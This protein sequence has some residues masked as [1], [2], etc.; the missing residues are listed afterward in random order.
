M[1]A[2]SIR[3]SRWYVKK[4]ARAGVAAGVWASGALVGR[5][6]LAP[7]VRVRALT[8][9]RFGHIPQDPFCVAPEDFEAQVR[10]L[11]ERKLAVSLDDVERFARGEGTL[12]QGGVLVTI[13]DGYRSTYSIAAPILRAHG[14]PAA[15]F[16]TASVIDD[17]GASANQPEPFMTWK[18]LA[19]LPR[20][21]VDVG[22]H[23][24][25]HRSL[26]A[27]P[28]E[29]GARGGRPIAGAARGAARLSREELR[30]PVRHARGLQP[31]DRA[32]PAGRRVLDRLQLAPRAICA[33]QDPIS[34]PRVKVEAGE[35][36]W[37]F[38][39]LCRG[40][41]DAWLLLDQTMW[42]LQRVR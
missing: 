7:R 13:D 10:W 17:A 33:D 11:A 32:A 5:S 20:W 19:E 6:L 24:Y 29:E 36:M 30:L 2:V 25:T 34:L 39:L 38:Q 37:M 9:H 22:S 14:V 23:A 27:M 41:M 35:G 42:R 31:A 26:G 28:L 15:A 18:E 12:P 16:V 40:A 1:A 8:Y 3:R 21:G 4:A